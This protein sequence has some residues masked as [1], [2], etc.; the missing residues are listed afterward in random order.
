M[1]LQVQT[2]SKC[3]QESKGL[4]NILRI[5]PVTLCLVMAQ[6]C[7]ADSCGLKPKLNGSETAK[8][9]ILGTS[10]WSRPTCARA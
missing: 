9:E 8:W 2:L 3:D 1:V 6:Q 10:S 5:A 4:Q 7:I